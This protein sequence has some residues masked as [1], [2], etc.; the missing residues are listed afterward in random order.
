MTKEK[1]VDCRKKDTAKSE[2][3]Q[4]TNKVKLRMHEE[5]ILC[6]FEI[7]FKKYY[8][9]ICSFAIYKSKQILYFE[10]FGKKTHSVNVTVTKLR[11]SNIEFENI[12]DCR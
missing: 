2:G 10:Y 9:C 12:N 3:S 6:R 8:Y 4:W 1:L 5:K 7:N 11:W